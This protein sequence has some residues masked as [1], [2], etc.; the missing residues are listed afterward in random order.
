MNAMI[1]KITLPYAMSSILPLGDG[2]HPISYCAWKAPNFD[3]DALE[4][5]Q[6]VA[7]YYPVR[8]L[9]DKNLCVVHMKRVILM[10]QDIR[11]AR[12]ICA[13]STS[14]NFFSDLLTTITYSQRK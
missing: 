7:E 10:P 12:G 8:L 11:L 14:H 2:D 9:D 6:E 1:P 13:E 3:V 5:L 4:A